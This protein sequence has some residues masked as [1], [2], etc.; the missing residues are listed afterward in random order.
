MNEEEPP[1]ATWRKLQARECEKCRD[2]VMAV[3]VETDKKLVRLFRQ[4]RGLR[5]VL[6][7]LKKMDRGGLK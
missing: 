1:C 7:K 6:K 5:Q 4:L 2:R 3:Q